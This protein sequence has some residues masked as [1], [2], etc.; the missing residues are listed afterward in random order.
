MTSDIDSLPV[1]DNTAIGSKAFPLG[2]EQRRR[3][4]LAQGLYCR[5]NIFVLDD[6][7]YGLDAG[8]SEEVF[9]VSETSVA[10]KDW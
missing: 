5:K 4:A 2:G 10:S 3:L 9:T 7:T 8:L 6:T 1:G